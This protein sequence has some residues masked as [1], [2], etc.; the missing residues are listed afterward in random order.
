M[1][2]ITFTIPDAKLP[3]IIA[4]MNG[5]FPVPQTNTGT[6]EEPVWEPEFTDGQWAKEAVRRWIVKQVQ[7]WEKKAALNAV[8]VQPEDDILT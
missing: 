6:E 7:R 4:A 3:R 1:A 5:F 8:D 2:E